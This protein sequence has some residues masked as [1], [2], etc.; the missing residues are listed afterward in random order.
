MTKSIVMEKQPIFRISYFD[1]KKGLR[2][3]YLN[4]G[5]ASAE[6]A[7]QEFNRI[8]KEMHSTKRLYGKNK[9]IDR[10]DWALSTL[11]NNK[12]TFVKWYFE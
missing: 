5:F 4:I 7:D 8:K 2:K 1:L 3:Y 6:E 9:W 11:T 10:K 12:D